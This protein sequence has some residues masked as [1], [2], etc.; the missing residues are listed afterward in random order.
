MAGAAGPSLPPP[1]EALLRLRGVEGLLSWLGVGV[2]TTAGST[3]AAG[4]A[5]HPGNTCVVASN[6]D[7]TTEASHCQRSHPKSCTIC[8]L[9]SPSHSGAKSSSAPVAQAQEAPT[10][11]DEKQRRKGRHGRESSSNRIPSPASRCTARPAAGGCEARLGD[12]RDRPVRQRSL[13]PRGVPAAH[14]RGSLHRALC[15]TLDK[16]GPGAGRPCPRTVCPPCRWCPP[17]PRGLSGSEG[18]RAHPALAAWRRRPLSH[19]QLPLLH[20]SVV[21]AGAIPISAHMISNSLPSMPSPSL[22][23]VPATEAVVEPGGTKVSVSPKQAWSSQNARDSGVS[24][25]S[26]STVDVCV[27]TV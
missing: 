25:A 5:K 12:E 2:A 4:I 27:S 9:P 21:A 15:R 17:S 14:A 6:T 22:V 8:K 24:W 7:G 23:C 10:S 19:S 26:I 20:S 1:P 18:C 16:A 3:R 11:E 13:H